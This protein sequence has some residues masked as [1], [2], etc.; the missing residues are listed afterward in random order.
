MVT[1][2]AVPTSKKQYIFINKRAN[3]GKP[4]VLSSCCIFQHHT[5][6]KTS[7]EGVTEDPGGSPQGSSIYCARAWRREEGGRF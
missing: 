1:K 6:A 4:D 3:E 2:L 7:G 5:S